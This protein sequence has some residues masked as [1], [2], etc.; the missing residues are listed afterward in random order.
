MK[1]SKL[2]YLLASF[3]LALIVNLFYFNY[4]QAPI[5]HPDSDLYIR[6]AKSLNNF[7]LPDTAMRTFVYPLYLSFFTTNDNLKLATY[8]QIFIGAISIA[9]L[10][11]IIKKLIGD[12]QISFW[13]ATIAGLDYHVA[14][15]QSAILTETIAVLTMLIF[16]LVHLSASDR[17]LTFKLTL[18][19]FLTDLLLIFTRPNFIMLPISVYLYRIFSNRFIK[20]NQQTINKNMIIFLVGIGINLMAITSW[21]YLNWARYGFFGFSSTSDITVLGKIIDYVYIDPRLTFAPFPA[22]RV[23]AYI[24]GNPTVSNPYLVINALKSEGVYSFAN[25]KKINRF[26]LQDKKIDFVVRGAVSLPLV[27]ISPHNFDQCNIYCGYIG[28]YYR[29]I[30]NPI[31]YLGLLIFVG[32]AVRLSHYRKTLPAQSATIILIAIFYTVSVST[33]FSYIGPSRFLTSVFLEINSLAIL[34]LLCLIPD[35]RKR[36]FK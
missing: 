33:W 25:I 18:L 31:R 27:F 29:W 28:D 8:G 16:I 19:L 10:F 14:S 4:Q 3:L 11:L 35:L 17:Q 13:I 12:M 5:I 22:D 6:F 24:K 7:E 1:K 23:I 26:F 32:V 20:Q 15:Y 21:S 9:I 34:I 2:N 30:I 36:L